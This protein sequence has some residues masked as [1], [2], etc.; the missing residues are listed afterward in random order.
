MVACPSFDFLVLLPYSIF[1][2]TRSLSRHK[3]IGFLK[4][5]VCLTSGDWF[6][7]A[8]GRLDAGRTKDDFDV[9]TATFSLDKQ[10]RSWAEED[11]RPL[12]NKQNRSWAEEDA[13][14]L[15]NCISL[16]KMRPF[17]D[18]CY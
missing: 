8:G 2:F 14:P 18:D 9:L 4:S 16:S 10:N 13:R 6:T 3:G 12:L 1:F 11:A 5:H 15:L 17:P 7:W